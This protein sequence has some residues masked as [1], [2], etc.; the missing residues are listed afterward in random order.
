MNHQLKS[1]ETEDRTQF[2]RH[3]YFIGLSASLVYWFILGYLALHTYICNSQLGGNCRTTTFT[4]LH[5]IM[6][7][8]FLGYLFIIFSKIPKKLQWKWMMVCANSIAFIA[9][10]FYQR[11][12]PTNAVVVYLAAL[13]A[14]LTF[15]VF[16]QEKRIAGKPP[17]KIKIVLGLFVALSMAMFLRNL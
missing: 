13:L 4:V 17:T 10:V 15:I 7:S 9:I 14:L 2:D 6:H 5:L 16:I 8:G 3:S 1:P 11:F 12:Y